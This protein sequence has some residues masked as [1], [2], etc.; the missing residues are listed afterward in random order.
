MG[1]ESKRE[2]RE[3]ARQARVEA[4][5]KRVQA[6]RR[7]QMVLWTA[8]IVVVA[9]GGTLYG[10]QRAGRRANVGAEAKR[11]GCTEVTKYGEQGRNHIRQGEPHAPY[12]SNPPSSG[13]HNGSPTAW[14]VYD[15]TVE[16]ETLVHNLEHGGVIVHYKDLKDDE[17]EKLEELIESYPDRGQGS[18]VILNPNP[19]IEK[20]VAMA[21][22]QR[23]RACDRLSV[24]VAKAFV[25]EFCA[26]GPEKFPLG[27]R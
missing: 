24:P 2:R 20:P 9:G 23:T 17:I 11:A 8:V 18:G 1:Q 22:W 27:C 5:R 12:N 25:E 4:Q 19:D 13:P 3:A 15:E 7:R 21:A 6:K 10:I 14:G 16:A 26:K